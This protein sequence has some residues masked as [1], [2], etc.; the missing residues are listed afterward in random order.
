[1]T[2]PAN[3]PTLLNPQNSVLLLIDFQP[4]MA[5]GVKSIDGQT[6]VNN[7][8]GLAKA[9]K[10]FNVPTIITSV[11]EKSFS[12]PT[13]SQLR[14]V[15]PQN[16]IIDR[17]TMNTWEDKRVVDEVKKTG[18]KKIV[19]AGL[20]TEVCIVMPTLDAL[21][22]GFEVYVVV[23]ACGGTS[24]VAHDMAVQ[25]MIQAGAQPITW[26]Q[27]LLELQR[28][29]ARQETYDAT[30]GIVKQHAGTYGIGIQYAKAV[31]GEA[32]NEGKR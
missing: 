14:D 6:L 11:A 15:F 13:F 24:P 4:Q 25:R 18:R 7:A 30:T 8:T 16:T 17:T 21:R 19:I 3:V 9:A 1:M 23:D 20:W 29:W 26:L 5:F 27:Y 22:E 12:G 10:V 2:T 32:A 28:D 31:L